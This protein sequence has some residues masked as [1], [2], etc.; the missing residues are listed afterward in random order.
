[1]FA[2]ESER[3]TR[4]R[5]LVR[6]ELNDFNLDACNNDLLFG[7]CREKELKI[8]K[9]IALINQEL[10]QNNLSENERDGL[11]KKLIIPLYKKQGW[12]CRHTAEKWVPGSSY[13]QTMITKENDLEELIK[14]LKKL[15]TE[16]YIEVIQ[17]KATKNPMI[18][19][20]S[21]YDSITGSI[22]KVKATH[23]KSCCVL[24]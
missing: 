1:M 22:I 24:I 11:F 6:N 21:E 14:E 18:A 3:Y 12:I 5:Q 8:N 2:S 9:L 17:E 23:T 15:N 13:A 10:T 7:Y 19:Y 20:S 4:L 16:S